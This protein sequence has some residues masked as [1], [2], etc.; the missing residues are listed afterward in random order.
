VTAGWID[1]IEGVLID[2][3]GTLLDGVRAIPGAAEA[4][5]R[6]RRAAI[7]FRLVTNTTRKPRTAIA[8]TLHEAGI[9]VRPEEILVPASLAARLI[10]DSGKHSVMLLVP[11]TCLEDLS[12]IQDVA[13]ASDGQAGGT[14]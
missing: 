6:L 7:P 12:G 9:E 4:L 8:R 2:V 1:G 14:S 3:D 5:N 10:R 11:E 13:G